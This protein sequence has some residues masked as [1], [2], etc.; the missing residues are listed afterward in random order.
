MKIF[1][2]LRKKENKNIKK[3]VEV[4][5]NISETDEVQSEQ[6]QF[7]TEQEQEVQEM[8]K[9]FGGVQPDHIWAF[10]AGHSS[11]DFRGNP[12]YLFAYINYYRPD[13]KTYWY[14]N[15]D[16]ALQQVR[17]LGFC[18]YSPE[19]PYIRQLLNRTGVLVVEQVKEVIPEGLENVKYVNLWHGIG[20][21][22]VERKL[23]EGDIAL[24]I[25][26]K[27]IK[28]NTFY[29]NNQLVCVT[30][31][32]IEKYMHDLGVD[33]DQYIRTGYPR[34]LYQQNFKPVVTFEHDLRKSR[35]LPADTKIAVY[36]PTFRAHKSNVFTRAFPDLE[37]L[38]HCCEE[39]H[40]LLIFKMHPYL[41]Q[42]TGF[43]KAWEQF[44]NKP[45]FLFWDNQ[46]DFY[47]VMHMTDLAIVDYS[48]ILSDFLAVGVHHFIRYIFDY[49]EYMESLPTYGDYFKDTVG[50]ICYTFEDFLNAFRHF[51]S[52]D[53]TED[54]ERL[55]ADLWSYSQ[56]KDD[57]ERIIR[58]VMD[59]HPKKRSFPTL[60]SFDIFDTLISRKVLD[61]IGVFYQVQE[62][63]V[64]HGGFSLEFERNYPSIRHYSEFSL[65]EYY[66]KTVEMR[67]SD[68]VEITLDEIFEKMSAIYGISADQAALL[69]QWELDAELENVIPL[70]KQIDL[71]KQLVSE[72]EKVILISD[73][74]L[75]REQITKMLAAADPV[76]TKL[77]LFLSNEYGVLKNS[78]KL[79]LEVYK[80]FQP[81]YDF[82]KWI[83][84]GDNPKADIRQPRQLNICTRKVEK[85]EFNN[86][87]EELTSHLQTSDA[88]LTAA[89]Q[90][91]LCKQH[92]H[93]YDDFVISFVSLCFV[94]YIDW[95]LR[96]AQRRGYQT[97]YFISRDGHHLKRI[98]DAMIRVRGLP[99]KTKLIYASRRTWRI[100]SFVHEVDDGFWGGYGN[101]V[102]ITSKEKLFEAMDVT[103]EQFH[104]LFPQIN[105]DT[106]DFMDREMFQGLVDIF[107]DSQKYRSFLMEQ[108]RKER[109]LVS[110]Y[111]KQEINP[112]EKFAFV[113]YFGRGYTQDCLVNLW[114]DIIGSE[115]EKIAF[116][117][118]RSVLPDTGGSIR[119]NFTNNNS[120]QFFIEA[121]FANMPYKSIEH[122]QE[123]NG[124]IIPVFVP[125]SY[126]KG[127]Y[128]SMMELLPLIA[129][130]YA[131]LELHNP[132]DTDRMLYDFMF[133]Y[134]KEH[135]EDP[136]FAEQ[137]GPLVDSVSVYG[138]KREFAPPFTN[139]ALDY[140]EERL[141]NRSNMV[142]TSDISVSYARSTEDIQHRYRHMYDLLPGDP[143]N[144]GRLLDEAEQANNDWYY[145]KYQHALKRAE[146]FAE[147]YSAAVE[148]TPVQKQAILVSVG[149]DEVFQQIA[150]RLQEN[151]YETRLYNKSQFRRKEDVRFAQELARSKY[152]I[153][154]EPLTFLSDVFLREESEEILLPK[155]AFY[156]YNKK[157]TVNYRLNWKRKY[158][159]MSGKNPVGVLQVPS[160]ERQE[161]FERYFCAYG[162]VRYLQGNCH[163]DV[164]FDEQFHIRSRQ[165]LVELMPEA[166]HKKV[167]CYMPKRLINPDDSSLE[168]SLDFQILKELI[169]EEYVVAV[170]IRTNADR[171]AAS[172]L[173]NLKDFCRLFLT[174]EMQERELMSAADVLVGDY[175]GV[176]FESAM[177]HK[178]VYMTV[179]DF[180]STIRVGNMTLNANDFQSFIFGPIVRN[181]F[182]LAEQLQDVENY[183][184]SKMESFRRRMF[185]GCSGHSV[186]SVME[187]LLSD[188]TSKKYKPSE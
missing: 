24:N 121:I 64:D 185:G 62:K 1:R 122:Y 105:I 71:V 22:T 140:L 177:L 8:H 42:E 117:Y 134:Y 58:K 27:Y 152:L 99:F 95:V 160:E 43:V 172:A 176:F 123:Q 124:K 83:H 153:V 74:Y 65:R 133:R 107:R 91:R 108:A 29:R 28:Y 119:Y 173:E 132:E 31:P 86:I 174:D 87:K 130:Q 187:Y 179:G 167:L 125:I 150:A 81:F 184:Y 37:R 141:V 93:A 126:N 106:V 88:Y 170:S 112:D 180:E 116:Y 145:R 59:F 5:E 56:G 41:E 69:K 128:D 92:Y 120:K 163:T 143:P 111:L 25:A 19:S 46:Y 101:F 84:Y 78:G 110:G 156:V 76:L 169:G 3:T 70:R 54:I 103:E 75:P 51:E 97:L 63:I 161:I 183:D 13:I 137:I 102:N 23:F 21:K 18:A 175:R 33:D 104:E 16:E 144:T 181:S 139:Q 109:V 12:K 47:E 94:P 162:P 138:K 67:N 77:P 50:E 68:H 34:C 7:E 165:K 44:G 178:P 182:D 48:S 11:Q 166:E 155:L 158:F 85:P 159:Q 146:S 147:C 114:R 80:S 118:S 52:L 115:D 6:K 186:D 135:R 57:F 113:E 96:D 171:K 61:P 90:A 10:T 98:A 49:N 168:S 148:E 79:F 157:L 127:L 188:H 154:D 131:G 36:S 55:N 142:L 53:Q 164:Y 15:N 66:H 45:Y 38:Y 100:P 40:I 82:D 4:H 149:T 60:Y 35:G 26:G 151:G 17:D 32:T 9:I 73:M 30:S 136:H 72:G 89:M 129:E 2:R 39:N 20:F 14:C